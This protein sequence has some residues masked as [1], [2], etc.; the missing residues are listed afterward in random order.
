MHHP[1]YTPTDGSFA[2]DYDDMEEEQVAATRKVGG[3]TLDY[4]QHPAKLAHPMRKY[5]HAY[6]VYLLG[7]LLLEIGFSKTLKNKEDTRVQ[8]AG[9]NKTPNPKY[10]ADDHYERRR[11]LCREYLQELRWI[12]GDTFAN[13]VLDCLMAD[14]SEDEVAKASQRELCARIIADLEGCQA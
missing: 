1:K 8:G 6:D 13:V 12:C 4:Y 11:W 10:D 2:D 5:Q 3:F 14:S 9:Y 7:V